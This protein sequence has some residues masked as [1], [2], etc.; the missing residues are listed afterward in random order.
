MKMMNDLM[1]MFIYRGFSEIVLLIKDLGFC[2]MN[3]DDIVVC[4]VV[5][6]NLGFRI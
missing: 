2:G 6:L 3:G 1:M 5:M 4:F